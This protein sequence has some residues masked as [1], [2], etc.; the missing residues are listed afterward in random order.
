MTF[1][2]PSIVEMTQLDGRT[3]R[4][5]DGHEA[6]MRGGAAGGAGSGASLSASIAARGRSV[7]QPSRQGGG[8][9]E[10]SGR[11]AVSP[12]DGSTGTLLEPSSTGATGGGT[13][14][15]GSD[16]VVSVGSGFGLVVTVVVEVVVSVVV[17]VLVVVSVVVTGSLSP[18]P[19]NSRATEATPVAVTIPNLVCI[20]E[21]LA[22]RSR[23]Q[24]LIATPARSLQASGIPPDSSGL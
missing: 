5:D 11:S 1:Q 9:S 4:R 21:L 20:L 17:F 2:P 14:A 24:Q 6:D 10:H 8:P 22:D 23:A 18:Q 3:G 7:D 16:V 12:A 19:T 15:G 13:I